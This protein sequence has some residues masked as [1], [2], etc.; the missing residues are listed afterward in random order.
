MKRPLPFIKGS[1]N[2]FLLLLL[3][4]STMMVSGQ[5]LNSG[6]FTASSVYP[7]AHFSNVASNNQHHAVPV[8]TC[9]T[10]FNETTATDSFTVYSFNPS[11]GVSGF[12]A[13]NN[14]IG[15]SAVAESFTG[16]SG[17]YVSSAYLLF[18]YAVY[19]I[20]DANKT[21]KIMAWDNSGTGGAPGRALDSATLTL[22]QIKTAV[23]AG[24][25]LQVT[26]PH[27][28]VMTTTGFYVGVIL[29]TTT[30]DSISLYTNL[31]DDVDGKGWLDN[32]GTWSTYDGT[33]GT[34]GLGN[35]IAAVMCGTATQA[36]PAVVTV[37][38][39]SIT[40]SGATLNGTVNAEGASSTTG[41]QYGLTTAYGSTATGVPSPVTGSTVTAISSAISGL[42]ASTL[43][44]FRAYATNSAGTTYGSDL[45]FTTLAAS[46]QPSCDTLFNM[47]SLLDSATYYNAGP[48][49]GYV[50]G[51]NIYGDVAKAEGFPAIAGY[52]VT[53]ADLFFSYAVYNM[54]DANLPVTIKIWDNTGTSN[55]GYAG[56]PGNAIDSA[57]VTLSQILTNGSPT[58]VNFTHNVALTT[59]TFYVGVVLPTNT[60]DTI[61]LYTNT[62]NGP[63]GDGWELDL[64]AGWGTYH[65]EWG[66]TPGNVGNFI[67]V[68][69]CPA[70]PIGSLA[71][72]VITTGASAVGS[73]TAT[74]NGSVN[75]N[76]VT[77]TTGF[78]WGLTTA[79]S[80]GTVAG[81]PSSLSTLVYSNVV[82][83]LTGLTASTTYHYRAYATNANGTTYGRDTTFTTLG[84]GNV[85]TPAV[86]AL[87]GVTPAALQVPCATQ[88]VA[89]SENYTLVVPSTV[90]F[91][92]TTLTVTSVTIDS[93]GNLPAGLSWSPGINPETIAGGSSGCYVISGT[94]NAACGE[95]LTPIY[96]TINIGFPV[97]TTLYATG[98]PNQFLQVISSG[99]S[100]P[101]PDT[102]Q[103]ATFVANPTCGVLAAPSVTVTPTAV[104]CHGGATGSAVANATGGNGTFTYLWSNG[105]TTSSISNVIAGTYTVTVTS[106]GQ[107]AT[108]SGTVTQPATALSVG[109]SATQTSCSSNTGT[110]TSNV[111]GGTVGYTYH[112]SNGA[113]TAGLTA[114]A[115]GTYTLTVT[116]A[117]GCSATASAVVS[118]PAGFTVSV[119][120]TNVNCYGQ[121]TGSATATA[122]GATG[123]LTFNWSN[124]STTQSLSN[125]AAGTYFVT[126]TET[127][128]CSSTGTGTITQP[129]SALSATASST[130]T[131][132]GSSTG[133]ATVAATG[134]TVG[135]GYTYSWNP[136]GGSTASISNLGVGNYTVTVTDSK[137]CTATATTSVNTSA[138]YIVN[139]TPTNVGCYGQSTG[140][141]TVTVTGANGT[142][143][144]AW[145]TGAT[146]QSVSALAAGTYNV[147][148]KDGSGCAKTGTAT[149][150]QPASALSASVT[151][152]QTA[153]SSNTGT[154]TAVVTGGTT[155]YSYLWSSTST[156][157]PATGLGSGNITL[158]VTD[159]N[160]C[161]TTASG[162]VSHPAPP[163]VSALASPVGCYGQSS[164]SVTTTVTG[165]NNDTYFWSNGGTAS[166]I[167]NVASGTYSVT[168]TD[169]FGCSA[170]ASATV[171]QPN[172]GVTVTT[173]TTPQSS[174]LTNNGSATATATNGSSPYSYLWSNSNGN[175]TI[176]NLAAGNY[177]VTVTDNNHCTASATASVNSPAN[178]TIA[179]TTVNDLCYGASTG[180][181]TV[182]VTGSGNYTYLWSN[183][184][185]T[186]TNTNLAAGTYGV[187]V[188]DA[189]GC[190]KAGSAV[191]TQPATALV[192]NATATNSTCG[193]SSGTAS[194]A[195]VGGT[196]SPSY[197]WNNND[198]TSS[199][200][201]LSVGVYSV[202]VTE[203]TCTAT[204]SAIVNNIN[205]PTIT[206]LSTNPSCSYNTDGS[207]TAVA[208]GGTSPYS[209]TWSNTQT[210]SSINNVGGGTY[211]VI[212]AD[213]TGCQVAGSV[214]LTA[215]AALALNPTTVNVNCEGDHTGSVT[216]AVAGGT[217]GY[218]YSWSNNTSGSSVGG[219][220]SGS[221]TVTV[222]DANHCTANGSFSITQPSAILVSTTTT[223]ASNGANG[224]ATASATGGTSPYSFAWANSIT[225][226]ASNLAAGTYTVTVTDANNCTA[227]ATATIVATG[228]NNITSNITDI[229]LI[230]N[231]ATDVVKV[232]VSLTSAQTV[233]FRMVDI[234]GKYVYTGHETTVQGNVTHTINLNE[235]AS[236]IYLVEISAGSEVIRKKLVIAR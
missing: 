184:V 38:A 207:A 23:T 131:A 154:A 68:D 93:I 198:I 174:C 194:V 9:D 185:I 26:F 180:S 136:G 12:V 36:A 128:G 30:G 13:G 69:L 236:G 91:Q 63:D 15:I 77:S 76:G 122:N 29:P 168:V 218:S 24:N 130:I 120:V 74:L 103:T 102:A 18:G 3:L 121:S 178:F 90:V 235:F 52:H 187:T 11:S 171:T 212:V 4:A 1:G 230:P 66:F 153:C 10:L 19:N 144:Y 163:S 222:T 92:G 33:Y 182:T 46:V 65:N 118:P 204:A 37:A 115:A 139:V 127:N 8:A 157:N 159:A 112:W 123:N 119:S 205:G 138:T 229:T 225:A 35:Y 85:C 51:N 181:A 135:A 208:S 47:I 160:Q 201:N 149:I 124:G 134:G 20:A 5:Q 193:T 143:T 234:T 210:T 223:D 183:S 62:Q 31:L 155:A 188:T 95:Y 232:V 116:D 190:A 96:V 161:S 111:T 6:R 195:V 129:V 58:V 109:A 84:A 199:I 172:S 99:H 173:S 217:P 94:T 49:N 78:Q 45:T 125:S 213:H 44:H 83:A 59:D 107:T 169:G 231:P 202:T 147:T 206:V 167:T 140:G 215:P 156:S 86:G 110:I 80:G 150:T 142:V 87:P 14:S 53:S 219:L 101:V 197:L 54:A 226:T 151:T 132:C 192:A 21:V 166:S 39:T 75:A 113:T 81:T 89:Y 200:S 7:A 137:S 61:V 179:I 126:V 158:T 98:V 233:E 165:S 41:F 175:A 108:A 203:G 221:I 88:G 106:S 214:T 170:S 211:V 224:T 177:T 67:A 72:S 176:S 162:S 164:G 25:L 133:S 22:S 82:Y 196:G 48:G 114:L 43:Y 42:Q 146:T 34:T 60:G 70:L 189:N 50:S 145:S 100:C 152:T 97:N 17:D 55:Q 191:I 16:V 105:A 228:I 117:N 186:T 209:Y 27:N 216:L 148:V 220:G 227:T 2:L 64:G 57:T 32:A 104:L 28:T 73:T 71:P 141:A 56:A 79:Y 40:S